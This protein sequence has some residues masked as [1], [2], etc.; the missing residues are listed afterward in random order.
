MKEGL[1]S[2]ADTTDAGYQMYHPNMV[3]R[4]E[5]IRELQ[6]Q[7][8]TFGHLW[9]P[10]RASDQFIFCRRGLIPRPPSLRIYTGRGV[11]PLLHFFTILN[12]FNQL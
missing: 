1:L 4:I 8:F 2:V 3:P 10:P 12:S 5:R 9:K 6:G 11:N 7:G